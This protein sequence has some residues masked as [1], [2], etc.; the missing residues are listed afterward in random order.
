MAFFTHNEWIT[1]VADSLHPKHRTALIRAI[2]DGAIDN[3]QTSSHSLV[4]LYGIGLLECCEG[5]SRDDLYYVPTSTAID[6]HEADL[7]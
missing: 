7:I 2:N 5:A 4:A 1:I 6:M 3:T